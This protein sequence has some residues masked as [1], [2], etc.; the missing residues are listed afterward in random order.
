[1]KKIF[2]SGMNC[3]HCETK[4]RNALSEIGCENIEVDLG[5]K[6]VT[7]S[8]DKKDEEIIE[9]IEDYGFDVDRIE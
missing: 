1:M 2:I 6:V 3:S 4:V 5:S 8:N 9:A 7:I